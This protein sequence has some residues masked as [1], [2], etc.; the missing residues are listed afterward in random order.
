MSK[1]RKLKQIRA[2]CS[3]YPFIASG[4]LSGLSPVASGTAGSAAAAILWYILSSYGLLLSLTAQLA[5]FTFVTLLGTFATSKFL[6]SQL[7]AEIESRKQG[8][9]GVVV[10]DEW[11]GMMLSL[12]AGNG[13][14][15]FYIFCAFFLFRLFD[16]WK[17]WLVN[18]LQKLP[19][20]WGVMLDDIGAGLIT[21]TIM[22]LGNFIV[23]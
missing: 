17:P 14:S 9:P 4:A 7:N 6:A 20:A 13:T 22:L 19:G 10:I 3:P 11:S 1:I 12:I 2:F 15:A 5:L 16:V 18:D 23:S 8:D 21:L